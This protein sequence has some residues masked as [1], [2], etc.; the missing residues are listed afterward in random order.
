M[1]T[2][3]FL[4]QVV[5]TIL[6]LSLLVGCNPLAKEEG[7]SA[8]RVRP[9]PTNS[10]QVSIPSA[11]DLSSMVLAMAPVV[12]GQGV[13]TA[14]EY[15]PDKPGP[16]PVLILSSSG[17]E[18]RMEQL[19]GLPSPSWNSNLP[20]GWL[21]ASVDKIELVVLVGPERQISLGSAPY[22]KDGITYMIERIR[23]EQEAEIRVARTGQ[24]L[25]VYS[26]VGSEPMDF[27]QIS[28]ESTLGGSRMGYQTLEAWLCPMVHR[29]ACW[30]MEKGI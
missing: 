13:S 22:T 28:W 4:N 11:S 2:Q 21:P 10:E 18:Y 8:P 1:N 20:H 24:T 15:D 12:S 30:V 5:G 7:K 14:S 26:F 19:T 9:L 29:Q 23:Y 17:D 25:A 6:I 27:P 16:H 3:K